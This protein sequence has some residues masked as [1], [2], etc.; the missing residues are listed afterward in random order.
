MRIVLAIPFSNILTIASI[1]ILFINILRKFNIYKR[2]YISARKHHT[3][4]TKSASP[5]IVMHFLRVPKL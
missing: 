5:T 2:Y 1:A 3:K 4:R